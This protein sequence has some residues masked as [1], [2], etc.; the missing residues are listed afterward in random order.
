MSQRAAFATPKQHFIVN[1]NTA[2][3]SA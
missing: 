2:T 1:I 3:Y